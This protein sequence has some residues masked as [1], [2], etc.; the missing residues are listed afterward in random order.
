MANYKETQIAGTQWTRSF[1]VIIDNPLDQTPRIIFMEQQATV[2]NDG[3]LLVQPSGHIE[4]QF[5]PSGRIEL[6]NP[7]DNQPLGQTVTQT[8]LYV[9]LH[10][11]YYKLATE[12]DASL[13]PPIEPNPGV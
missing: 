1:R 13:V 6:I 2:L 11:L 3:K 12:R 10:S 9:I 4:R 7:T 8:D 5:D